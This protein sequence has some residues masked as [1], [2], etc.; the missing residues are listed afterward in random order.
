MD[1]P[2]PVSAFLHA[3]S[4]I[5]AGVFLFFFFPILVL[6]YYIIIF[7]IFST[8]FFSLTAL[9]YFDLKKIIAS[10]TGSQM[11]Y[12]LFFLFF[13]LIYSGLLLFTFHAI[14]KSLLFFLAGFL[15]SE[16]FNFQDIR[17]LK[18]GFLLIF[19]VIICLFSLVGLFF[20]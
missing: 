9:I 13:G 7:S 3:A 6:N 16:S 2:T 11:G 14:F 8:I 12:I 18:T 5:T 15:I 4:M 17:F 10:S 20:F 19:F 1:G